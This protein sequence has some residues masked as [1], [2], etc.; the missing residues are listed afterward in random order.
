MKNLS[1]IEIRS[2]LNIISETI[3]ELILKIHSLTE[4][5]ILK[6]ESD[7]IEEKIQILK[8]EGETLIKNLESL[9]IS[10]N[11]VSEVKNILPLTFFNFKFNQN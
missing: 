8:I 11:K 1:E 3:G 5:E 4:V 9:T 10:K 2:R 7:L 6:G